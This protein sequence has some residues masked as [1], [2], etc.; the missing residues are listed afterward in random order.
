MHDD[1]C[2]LKPVGFVYFCIYALW[3]LYIAHVGYPGCS[4]V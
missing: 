1:I 3:W 2:E 4:L